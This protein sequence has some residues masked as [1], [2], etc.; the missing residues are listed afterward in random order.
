MSY[1]GIDVGTSQT[2]AT[3][4]DESLGVLAQAN[5]AYER[6]YPRPGWCELDPRELVK[7]VR[8]VVG[9]CATECRKDPIAA[10]SFSV[11]GGGIW[12][13]MLGVSRC[14]PSS[15]P[16]TTGLRPR[17]MIGPAPSAAS[18]LIASPA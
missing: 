3:A 9:R 8:E 12:R 16:R 4:F 15:A 1:L 7:A 17:R 6:S 14:C 5:A 11:L 18:G 2:K 13:S 10:L